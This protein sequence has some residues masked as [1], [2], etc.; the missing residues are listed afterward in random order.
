LKFLQ[1][2]DAVLRKFPKVLLFDI[3]T[4]PLS[5]YVFQKSIWRANITEEQVISEWFMLTWSAKWL[6][7]GNVMTARLTGKEAIQEDDSRITKDFWKLLDECDIAIAHNGDGF[8]IPNMNTRFIVNN[9]PPPSPYKTIDTLLV[10]RQ[11]FGFTHNNLNALA[12]IFGFEAKKDTDIELWKRCVR[13]EEKALTYMQEYNIGDTILLENV[14][15]KLRPWIRNHPNIGLYIDSNETVC[16]NCGSSNITWLDNKFHY[17]GVS[18]FPLFVCQCGAYGRG[19]TSIITK[20]TNP[21]L[22]VSLPVK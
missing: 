18:K 15:L 17:T 13:G 8:D 9:L 19:R 7:D 22:V 14:Y 2:D 11:Q 12:R 20:K 6:Y 5:A 3:E 1:G 10:A 16:P 21:N 4:A